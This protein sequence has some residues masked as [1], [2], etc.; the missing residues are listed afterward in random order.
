MRTWIKLFIFLIPP[1]IVFGIPLLTL[2]MGGELTSPE[3]VIK[4]QAGTSRLVL[5]GA[6]LS[7]TIIYE[8]VRAMQLRKPEI[9]ALGTSRV[10]QFRQNF[11]K[12]GIAFYNGGSVIQRIQH[13]RQTLGQLPKDGQPRILI[14][15]IEQA[16]FNGNSAYTEVKDQG[17]AWFDAQLNTGIDPID[18]WRS[19]CWKVWGQL[20]D[21]KLPVNKVLSGRGLTD[22][23]GFTSCVYDAGYRNDGSYQYRDYY[24]NI[25]DPR[26]PD[27]DFSRGFRLIA[28]SRIPFEKGN[29]VYQPSVEELTKFLDECKARNIRVVGFLPPL[30]HIIIEKLNAEED[31]YQYLAKLYPALAP[32]FEA[33]GFEFYDYSDFAMLGATDAE[34][35]DS[36][37]GSERVYIKLCLSLVEKGSL[38][39]R[40]FDVPLLRK[41]LESRGNTDLVPAR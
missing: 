37:H 21:G 13:L 9:L 4:R 35:V 19:N 1:G 3:T 7:N 11:F 29:D 40:E 23:I 27:R 15:G 6:A 33:R 25:S 24:F 41:A 18:I 22:R 10:L 36:F 38:L 2:W 31:K 12:P 14:V 39:A 34:A 17:L 20:W 32:V 28:T 30:P 16:W 5:H 8:K 26:H